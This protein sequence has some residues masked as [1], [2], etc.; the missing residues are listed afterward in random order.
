M[1]NIPDLEF[2]NGNTIPQVGYGVF[3]IPPEETREAVLEAFRAGY[4]HID[5][6]A[7]YDNE[8]G[9]GAALAES[10]LDRSDVFVTTKLADS[11]MGRTNALEQFEVSLEKL[12]TDYVDLYLIHWPMP[13]QDLFVET[14]EALLEIRESGK[15]TNVGVSNF[16]VHHLERLRQETAELPVINQIEL[17]PWLVQQ[18]LRDYHR[19]HGIVTEAWS[20]LAKGGEQLE[21]PVVKEIA[22]GHGR[23][24]AQVLLRWHLQLGNVII[25]KSVTPSRMRE[26]LELF[27]FELSPAEAE[28][29]SALD[30]GLRTGPD[31][32]VRGA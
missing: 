28:R 16:Q 18:E 23:T 31:P 21:N 3:K 17:H 30:E 26:N 6:A 29:L 15:A 2:R 12:G 22:A 8:E 11:F 20:P 24:P 5:T 7:L 27:D 1:S 4:R 32:D 13:G 14:W 25:P 10:G 19:E 9:V